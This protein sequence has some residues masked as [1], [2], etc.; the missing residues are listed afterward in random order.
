VVEAYF[1]LH[2]DLEV[3]KAA[4]FVQVDFEIPRYGF[5]PAAKAGANPHTRRAGT[6]EKTEETK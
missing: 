4:K 5:L 6:S 2:S 3:T 1:L